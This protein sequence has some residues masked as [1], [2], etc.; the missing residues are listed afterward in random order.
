MTEPSILFQ[1]K[2]FLC[3][4]KFSTLTIQLTPVNDAVAYFYPPNNDLSTIVVF[5]R[6]NGD[7]FI[8]P[9][10]FLFHEAGHF[11][12]WSDYYQRQQSNVF[13]ELIQIDHGRKK[14]QFEQE[15]W[16]HGEKLLIEFLN[17]AEI[18]PNHYLDD[19]HKLQKLSLAT[20]NIET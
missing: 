20:Y 2:S 11:R 18:K 12:Q 10:V 13:L 16:L 17:V 14:V 3:W 5:Y 15:A 6:E 9:L 1:A 19:Y 7:N 8:A 4:E